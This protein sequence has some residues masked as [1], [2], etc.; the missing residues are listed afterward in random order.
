MI[1]IY[2][3]T[4]KTV[5]GIIKKDALVYSDGGI[6]IFCDECKKERINNYY[7]DDN[8]LVKILGDE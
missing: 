8:Q 2:C 5:V 1:N 3:D 7:Y 4:C 6:E